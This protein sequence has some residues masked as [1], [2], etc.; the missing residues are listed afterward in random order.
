MIKSCLAAMVVIGTMI[1]NGKNAV[2]EFEEESALALSKPESMLGDAF[3]ARLVSAS[4]STNFWLRIDAELVSSVV[5]YQK[6][7]TGA[8]ASFFEKGMRSLSNVVTQTEGA[9]SSWQFWTG[10]L[11][12]A[13]FHAADNRFSMSYQ[14][15]TNNIAFMQEVRPTFG[16]NTLNAAILTYYEMPGI[17]MPMAFN[18]FAGMSAAGL[19]MTNVAT[20]YARQLSAP[21]SEIILEFCQ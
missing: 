19:G 8:D 12:L 1:A 6:F 7:M 21:Y 15:L 10:R 9:H 11:L 5:C 18:V 4:Q 17:S 20:N 13:G 3:S 2:D 14:M 16:T